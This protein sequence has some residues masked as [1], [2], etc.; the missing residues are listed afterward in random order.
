MRQ[1]NGT[2][3]LSPSDLMVFLACRHATHLDLRAL[4]EDLK[5]SGDDAIS[6]LLKRKGIEHEAQHLASLQ[7]QHG[8][9]SIEVIDA[10]LSDSDREAATHAAMR[11]GAAVVYQAA[12]RSGIWRGFADFLQRVEEPSGLGNFSYEAVDT[13]LSRQVHG[14]YALQLGVYSAFLETAQK[15]R[16]RYM[17]VQL[18]DGTSHRL[19][20]NDFLAYL[21]ETAHRL[22][23]FTQTPPTASY[24][25]RCSYCAQCGW[26]DNCEGQWRADDHLVQVA[27]I[28]NDA[29]E[30]LNRA[31]IR[32]LKALAE[33][34]PG[35]AAP[36]VSASVLHRLRTQAALQLRKRETGTNEYILLPVSTGHGF[37]LLPEPDAGDLFFDMEGDPLY[38]GG[39]EYLFGFARRDNGALRYTAYWAHEKEAERCVTQEVISF[40]ADHLSKHPKAHVYHYNTYEDR[41]LKR[42]ASLYGTGEAA[43]TTCCARN[44]S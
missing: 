5:K 35:N 23:A 21:N 16:P 15:R 31:G 34:P 24:P 2:L 36:G 13:K 38:P 19:R 41:A 39:L 30:V 37:D 17:H 4:T 6:R 14:K 3:Y 10:E 40:L 25:V 44:V 29:I 18:G 11:R 33:L 8:E 9:A 1:V 22:V 7:A 27:N 42:L 32:T 28:R 20:V 26:R 43:W 12:L